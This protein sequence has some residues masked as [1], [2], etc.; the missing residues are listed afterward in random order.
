M[1]FWPFGRTEK[2]ES[3]STDLLQFILARSSDPAIKA[4]VSATSAAQTTAGMIGRSLAIAEATPTRA[5]AALTAPVLYDIGRAFVLDGEIVYLIRYNRAAGRIELDRA[6]DWDV[7]DVGPKWRYRL[8]IPGAHTTRTVDVPAETVF[9]PR[10]NVDRLMPARGQAMIQQAGLTGQMLA[11]IESMIGDEV[12]AP[13]GYVLPAPLDTLGDGINQLKTDLANL[14]GKTA[15]VPSMA[16]KWGEG[17]AGAPLRDWQPQRLGANPPDVLRALRSD[18]QQAMMASVG[19]PPGLFA[20]GGDAAGSREA[21]RQFLHSTLQ[22]LGDIIANEATIK[23]GADVT[24]SFD[25]LFA[26]DLQGRARAFQ[27]MVQGGMDLAQAAEAAG[28]LDASDVIVPEPS[29][30]SGQSPEDDD[31]ATGTPNG[32]QPRRAR[33]APAGE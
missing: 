9:H 33:Q 1:R 7:R 6:A 18:A 16:D 19:V 2:R 3:Y 13:C 27:S 23:F 31:E 30:A 21:L 12:L 26:A 4:N 11:A 29:N 28:I 20:T 10:V 24:F 17:R 32:P 8:T 5:Q 15:L 25:R 14:K 22:P